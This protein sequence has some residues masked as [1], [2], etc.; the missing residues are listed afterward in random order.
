MIDA[1]DASNSYGRGRSIIFSI[2]KTYKV[3]RTA[4]IF[5]VVLSLEAVICRVDLFSSICI[6]NSA[7]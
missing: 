3:V 5:F 4:L 2:S 1:D 7:E 6:L